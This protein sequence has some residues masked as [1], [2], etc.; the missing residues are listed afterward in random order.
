T[1]TTTPTCQGD[2]PLRSTSHSTLA[3]QASTS[4]RSRNFD[5]SCLK[6]E[7]QDC[8]KPSHASPDGD[9]WVPKSRVNPTAVAPMFFIGEPM[10]LTWFPSF[11]N[12][13][14][15]LLY[16]GF[17]QGVNADTTHDNYVFAESIVQRPVYGP[18]TG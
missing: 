6:R 15:T 17:Y 11:C 12:T 3:S 7:K 2:S 5:E 13:T 16:S 1:S 14:Y 4:Q 10:Y 8:I 18:Y 9:I